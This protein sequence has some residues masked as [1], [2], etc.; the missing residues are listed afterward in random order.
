MR[1]GNY[2][3]IK[4]AAGWILLL[5]LIV[6]GARWIWA[7]NPVRQKVPA[8]SDTEEKSSDE[9]LFTNTVG[10]L[11][12]QTFS[13]LL[14]SA[15]FEQQSQFV[16][17]PIFTAPRMA[18]FY[19][20]NPLPEI[21]VAHVS[22]ARQSVVNLPTGRALETQWTSSDGHVLDV[23]FMNEKDEW[24]VDWEHY[25]RFSDFPLAL[26]LAG[27]GQETGE[28]RLLA[29]ERLAEERKAETTLS[30]TFYAPRFG[31]SADTGFQSPEFTVRRDSK[32]GRL[33]QQAFDLNKSGAQPFGVKLA[34]ID[35]EGLIRVRLKL[36]RFE[37]NEERRF[38]VEDVIV[39]HWYST[40]ASG[41]PPLPQPATKTN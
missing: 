15:T 32:N 33:L 12:N 1:K 16:S 14:N 28:F 2:L 36:R 26:F 31:F 21:N 18:R 34:N 6:S 23:V 41:M 39:C 7:E 22:L 25:A 30:L 38:E 20:M 8:I 5:V 11:C 29:R 3:I 27:S 10:P 19:S 9:S 37:A 40:D 35:P 24:R 4:I 13:G 17:N